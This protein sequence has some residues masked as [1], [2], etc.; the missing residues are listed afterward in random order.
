MDFV[1]LWYLLTFKGYYLVMSPVLLVDNYLSLYGILYSRFCA[2]FWKWMHGTSAD[3]ACVCLWQLSSAE[4][5]VNAVRGHLEVTFT[6]Y[7]RPRER[8]SPVGWH[9]C[10]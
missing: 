1:G 4:A 6:G 3:I 9:L 10:L 7:T 2:L 8:P 5:P